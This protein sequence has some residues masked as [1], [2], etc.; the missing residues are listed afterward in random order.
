MRLYSFG[1]KRNIV[2]FIGLL[3]D[4]PALWNEPFQCVKG[5]LDFETYKKACS[6]PL[7]YPDS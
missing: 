3:G 6:V 1:Y 2:V 7:L 5:A 4:I